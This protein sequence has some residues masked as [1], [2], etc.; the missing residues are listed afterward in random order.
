MKMKIHANATYE[1]RLE[2]EGQ[3]NVL[4]AGKAKTDRGK[5]DTEEWRALHGGSQCG[6]ALAVL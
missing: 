4:L 2:R 6:R 3:P 1:Q 5:E